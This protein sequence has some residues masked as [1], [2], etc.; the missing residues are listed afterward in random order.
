[1]N[2]NKIQTNQLTPGAIFAIRGQVGFSRITRPCTD[3]ER[4]KANATKTH[5]DDKN[6]TSMT[7]YNAQALAKNPAQPTLEECY[8]NQSLYLAKKRAQ[9]YPGPNFTGKNKSSNLPKVAVVDA[10]QPGV[11]KELPNGL[12]GELAKGT[13]VTLIMRVFSTSS[14]NGVSLDTVLI[15]T[16]DYQLFGNNAEAQ[17]AL[18][19]EYGITYEAA[20]ASDRQPAPA[21]NVANEQTQANGFGGFGAPG[22]T[23]AAAP[24]SNGNI[25]GGNASGVAFGSPMGQAAPAATEQAPAQSAPVNAA[26]AVGTPFNM[27]AMTSPNG[28]PAQEVTF[29]VGNVGVGAGRTY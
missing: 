29:G 18:L 19:A 17:S 26:G 22:A 20:P 27:N 25:F 10:N 16:P 13:D 11:Y 28:Q 24:Q 2:G 9:D 4:I 12:P 7:L 1:M 5:K 21:T 8:G 23:G 3:E 14:N 15:N 6:Y